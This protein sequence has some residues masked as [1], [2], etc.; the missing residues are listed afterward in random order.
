MKVFPTTNFIGTVGSSPSKSYSHR[1]FALAILANSPST[2]INPLTEGDLAVTIEFCRLF[3]AQ[4]SE[5]SMHNHDL[6]NPGEFKKYKVIPPKRLQAPAESYNGKNSGTSIRLM[7]S[8]A[9]L[10]TEKTQIYGTFFDRKRPMQPLL[11]A[12]S[13]IGVES[14]NTENPKGIIITPKATHAGLIKIPGDISSQFITGLMCLAPRLSGKETEIRITTPA[15]SYPYLQITEEIFRDFQIKFK[16]QFNSDL[17]GSYFI[18]GDQTYSGRNYEVP[19]D[20]SSAAFIFVGAALN[21]KPQKVTMTNIDMN[22]PQGDKE[23][24]NI[25]K[26]MG[27]HIDINSQARSVTI[28]G[29]HPLTGIRIDCS[30]IPDLFPIL[31]VLGCLSGGETTIFNAAHVR[32]KETDRIKVMVRELEKMGAKVHEQ[33]DGIILPGN[34]KLHGSK[35]QHDQDHRIAMCLSIATLY[36][37]SPSMLERSEVVADSYPGFWEDLKHLGVNLEE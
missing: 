35:I 28:E 14:T 22:N 3:G 26:R 4:I 32:L 12:L 8:L 5:E 30:Q 10:C 36:A 17:L 37:D 31:C 25:L 1:A 16:S 18:P 21:P 9:A 34:Q 2:I 6:Q 19:G 33:P 15:K 24:I 23:I 20:F 11:D 29:G 13:Q 27:A 7:T